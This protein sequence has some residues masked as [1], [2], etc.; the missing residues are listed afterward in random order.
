MDKQD[1]EK[2]SIFT[3]EMTSSN[4][5]KKKKIKPVSGVAAP[6]V[7]LGDVL[8]TWNRRMKSSLVN[9]LFYHI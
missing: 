9:Y 7:L 4:T 1:R 5:S 6:S 2:L 8:F 3:K